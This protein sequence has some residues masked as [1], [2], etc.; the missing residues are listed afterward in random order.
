MNC[1][2]SFYRRGCRV[3]Q[4]KITEAALRH[5]TVSLFL[6]AAYNGSVY[7]VT[8]VA[9]SRSSAFL[10]VLGGE[11]SPFFLPQCTQTTA[12]ENNRAALRY[13]NVSLFLGTVYTVSACSVI[14]VAISRFS[15]S[16]TASATAPAG[17][18]LRDCVKCAQIYPPGRMS[19]LFLATAVFG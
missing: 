9:I 19:S 5:S 11:F 16:A 7:S 14:S 13:S 3:P 4:K 18:C 12:K 10:R 2:R 8:S 17:R 6:G 1:R 15:A